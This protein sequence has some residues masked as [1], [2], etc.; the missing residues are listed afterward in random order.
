MA[1]VKKITYPELKDLFSRHEAAKPKEHL[2]AHIVFAP[3]S[4]AEAYSEKSRTYIVSSNNKAFQPNMCG[5]SIFASCL[6][7]TDQ[8]V[9]LSNYMKDEHGGKDGWIVAYCYLV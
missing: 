1:N 8:C 5:Y 7:G 4:F 2:T 3:E 6:D 9:R